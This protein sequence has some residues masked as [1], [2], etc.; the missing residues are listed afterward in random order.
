M[1]GNRQRPESCSEQSEQPAE[2]LA[3]DGQAATQRREAGADQIEVVPRQ[4][5]ET[6]SEEP[7]AAAASENLELAGYWYVLIHYTDE[8]NDSPLVEL[9]DEW[10]G[11]PLPNTG[12][13]E[14]EVEF[15][16]LSG[17]CPVSMP[18]GIK[19]IIV[20]APLL[21]CLADSQRRFYK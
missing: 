16:F 11:P 21:L 14:V 10:G 1:P 19:W 5:R 18:F 7:P 15:N 6:A 20:Q 13:S 4:S 3:L 12:S 2:A 8:G 17:R 9:W